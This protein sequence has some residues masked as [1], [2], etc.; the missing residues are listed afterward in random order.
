MQTL[1]VG[2]NGAEV[3]QRPIEWSGPAGPSAEA[4]W[5]LL[6]AA[7]YLRGRMDAVCAAFHVTT[8]QFSVLRILRAA[9]PD[10][11]SRN[12][13]ARRMIDRSPDVTRLV[14]RLEQQ[15]FVERA[16]SSED[17]RLSV[18]RITDLG[19]RLLSRVEP[20]IRKLERSCLCE[21]LSEQDCTDLL[22]LCQL[23]RPRTDARQYLD[24]AVPRS[25][26][27][28]APTASWPSA[29]QSRPLSHEGF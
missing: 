27:S 21:S 26:P 3:M 9:C 6:V 22:R 23:I 13:I 17:R 24:R 4:L 5:S 18:T 15:Q 19:L 28:I 11:Y 14:D 2:A 12:E 1:A 29:T 20:E 16:R 8:S 25:S 7:D 10:G